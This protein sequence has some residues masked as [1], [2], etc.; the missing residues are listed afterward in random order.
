MEDRMKVGATRTPAVGEPTKTK[1][2]GNARKRQFVRLARLPRL[3]YYGATA[4]TV[5]AVEAL[6][7]AGAVDVSSCCAIVDKDEGTRLLKNLL[8][9][10][11][12]LVQ[13]GPMEWRGTTKE[14]TSPESHGLHII[15]SATIYDELFR[16]IRAWTRMGYSVG[17]IKK[18]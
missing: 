6:L 11:T 14:E 12:D 2:K 5:N 8:N 15:S 7:N 9:K 16:Q 3:V 18:E 1:S 17:A 4:E 13:H 10:N